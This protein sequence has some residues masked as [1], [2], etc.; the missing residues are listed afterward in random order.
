MTRCVWACLL[1]LGAI[2]VSNA[3]A[4]QVL[5]LADVESKAKVRLERVQAWVTWNAPRMG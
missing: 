4:A 2:M 5:D 1:C 3:H